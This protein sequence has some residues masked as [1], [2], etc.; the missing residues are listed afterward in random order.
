MFDTYSFSRVNRNHHEKF[1]AVTEFLTRFELDVDS[2]VERFVVAKSNEQ[3]IACGGLAGS[4]LKS[5]A[6]DPAL[7]GTGFSL[8]LMTELTAMAYEMGRFDLFLFTKPEN[9][10][11]FRDSGFFPIATA[12]D[13]LVLMENGQ[14]NLRNY[15][16]RLKRRKKEGNKIGSIVMNANPFT[17]GHQYLIETAALNCDWLHLFVVGEEGN[18]FSYN[19]RVNMISNGIKHIPNITIHPGSKYIISK[20]TFPTYFIK[21]EGVIDF[22]HTAIDLNIF[23]KYI[24][25][26]LGVT[27]RFVGTEP[28]CLV[29]NYYN[30]QMKHW[31]TTDDL[32]TPRV[33]VIEIERKC[34]SGIPISASTVRALLAQGEYN[35]LTKFLPQTSVDY[36]KQNTS[37]K[38]CRIEEIAAA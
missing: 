24:A 5:I 27:H 25:P 33:E 21:D 7:H 17:L 11:L 29:T 9:A 12:E 16:R 1:I 20:A 30:Q 32:N 35:L 38:T 36:L 8:N 2:D 34:L 14:S 31:L 28:D 22:C 4:I 10:K 3:I 19:D 13:K 23:R 6:I 15:T 26:A 18:D 37:L